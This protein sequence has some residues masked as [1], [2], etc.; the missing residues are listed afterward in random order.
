MIP[1]VCRAKIA[2][3]SRKYPLDNLARAR[4]SID[5]ISNNQQQ[6]RRTKMKTW[7]LWE[8]TKS[9]TGENDYEVY[10]FEGEQLGVW[11]VPTEYLEPYS[12]VTYYVY[13]TKSG[14]IIIQ[15]VEKENRLGGSQYSAIFEYDT[16]A[17]AAKDGYDEVLYNMRVTS[18]SDL[19]KEW[20][21]RWLNS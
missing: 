10:E 17:D 19:V 18:N 6:E 1:P 7:Q 9:W 12:D 20:R 21:E 5:V 4:Y 2:Q 14:C 11:K 3:K 16:L 13:Q 15:C 8:G